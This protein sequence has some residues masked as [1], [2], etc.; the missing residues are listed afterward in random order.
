MIKRLNVLWIILFLSWLVFPFAAEA[1]DIYVDTTCSASGGSGAEADPYCLI[2]EAVN[3]SSPGDVVAGF[4][5]AA[6][7]ARP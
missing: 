2:Q 1:T 4:M 6:N 7:R 5:A 3:N